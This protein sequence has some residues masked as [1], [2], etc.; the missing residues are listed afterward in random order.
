MGES[1]EM[2]P[3]GCMQR[4]S[5]SLETII[6][7]WQE[8]ASDKNLSS[9]GSRQSIIVSV[10]HSM[11]VLAVYSAKNSCRSSAEQYLSNLLRDKTQW[12]SSRVSWETESIWFSSAKSSAF[13]GWDD[14]LIRAPMRVLVSNTTL[15][16]WFMHEFV[17]V[18]HREI[19][20]FRTYI[21][22]PRI[23]KTS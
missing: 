17:N 5:S 6:F 12:S 18:C 19:L 10:I 20:C 13:P 8:W 7:A 11:N 3:Y 14:G 16:S 9:P 15:Y 1:I 23:E 22:S 21:R 4:R 2:V